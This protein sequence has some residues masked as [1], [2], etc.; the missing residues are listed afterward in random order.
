[1][2]WRNM[3]HYDPYKKDKY[4]WSYWDIMVQP[5]LTAANAAF[6]KPGKTI[7]LSPQVGG[8][9]VPVGGG[10]WFWCRGCRSGRGLCHCGGHGL[11]V[12][13]TAVRYPRAAGRWSR[14]VD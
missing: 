5:M 9:L 10:G 11:G 3:L 13:G 7:W 6:Q 14:L 4:G 12:V 1:M 2:H 8:G